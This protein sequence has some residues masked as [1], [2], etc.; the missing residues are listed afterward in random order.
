MGKLLKNLKLKR[1]VGR[2]KRKREQENQEI[3]EPKQYNSDD[4][5]E[6]KLVM[7]KQK[8]V[9]HFMRNKKKF[10][11]DILN[12]VITIIVGIILLGGVGVIIAFIPDIMLVFIISDIW[13]KNPKDKLTGWKIEIHLFLH[14]IVFLCILIISLFIVLLISVEGFLVVWRIIVI[15]GVHIVIDQ[16]THSEQYGGHFRGYSRVNYGKSIKEE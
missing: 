12:T 2:I 6:V 4:L 11:M 9:H 5:S 8:I 1:Q 13:Q 14:S 15:L 10:I 16:I 3:L 7:V